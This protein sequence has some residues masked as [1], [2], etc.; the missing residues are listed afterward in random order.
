M[1]EGIPW[2]DFLSPDIEWE[3]HGL[4]G[5]VRTV[6]NLIGDLLKKEE[7]QLER[8]LPLDDPEEAGNRWEE[9]DRLRGKLMPRVFRYSST[10]ALVTGVEATLGTFVRFVE[11]GT[12][13]PF[14]ARD[15]RRRK[16]HEEQ[17]SYL[18]GVGITLRRLQFMDRLD[19]L[20][21]VRNCMV[22]AAGIVDHDRKPERVRVALDHLPG[23]AL[24]EGMIEVA[25]DAVAPLVDEAREWLLNVAG[26]IIKHFHEL[27]EATRH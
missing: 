15:R 22:H 17:W 23:F 13:Q 2:I 25:A 5:Y 3:F 19:N 1:L 11:R 10:T 7:E 21:T 12:G 6:E 18:E 26:M 9:H 14:K 4:Y 24:S 20:A 8:V 27:Y 16:L